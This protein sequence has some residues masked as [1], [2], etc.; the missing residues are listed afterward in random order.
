MTD[1]LYEK[2]LSGVWM[3]VHQGTELS[4]RPVGWQI[5][6][7]SWTAPRQ[8]K[9]RS[10][11]YILYA[12]TLCNATLVSVQAQAYWRGE[13]EGDNRYPVSVANAAVALG[14]EGKVEATDQ[15]VSFAS[16]VVHFTL[17]EFAEVL[18]S[19][20][21]RSSIE[22]YRSGTADENSN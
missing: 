10:A 7:I 1:G 12:S 11:T 5:V 9:Q 20:H 6:R 4:L 14:D 16:D 17:E 3:L 15:G 19:R 8:L 2:H 21:L 22:F 18:I 13:R